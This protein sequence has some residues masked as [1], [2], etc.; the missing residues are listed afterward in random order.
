M[1]RHLIRLQDV[2]CLVR[3]K[4]SIEAFQSE[5]KADRVLADA[6]YLK[7]R[8]NIMH[9]RPRP[10]RPRPSSNFGLARRVWLADAQ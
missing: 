8:H 1:P 2:H 5:P 6:Q 9:F 3:S 10:L 7:L 4:Q